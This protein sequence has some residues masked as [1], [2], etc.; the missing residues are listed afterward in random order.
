MLLSVS[1][2]VVR[3]LKARIVGIYIVLSSSCKNTQTRLHMDFFANKIILLNSNS[4]STC[5][6]QIFNVARQ[7]SHTGDAPE[8]MDDW[9]G[10]KRA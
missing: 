3:A 9:V 8:N 5:S 1:V 2:K 6:S 7:L 10:L 4:S